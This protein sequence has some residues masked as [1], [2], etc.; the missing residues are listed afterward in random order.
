VATRKN[1]LKSLSGGTRGNL[2]ILTVLK[3]MMDD[4]EGLVR[5]AAIEALIKIAPEEEYE[6]LEIAIGKIGDRDSGVKR[7]VCHACVALL[8]ATDLPF[9]S[10]VCDS[11]ISLLKD[12][13]AEVRL[14]PLNGISKA[15]VQALGF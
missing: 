1:A 5:E 9:C 11:L 12:T 8:D 15:W 7:A 4:D 14:R 3:K 13:S 2:I 10:T 6:W